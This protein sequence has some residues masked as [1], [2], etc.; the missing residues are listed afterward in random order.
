M[1]KLEYTQKK[2]LIQKQGSGVDIVLGDSSTSHLMTTSFKVAH[3][4]DLLDPTE[5]DH[6]I[7]LSLPA[8]SIVLGTK[9]QM[10]VQDT[11]DILKLGTSSDDDLFFSGELSTASDA[12]SLLSPTALMSIGADD[13]G[14]IVLT[15]S[16]AP[17]EG[18][19]VKVTVTFIQFN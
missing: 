18:A 9:I 5:T 6:I 8:N 3:S 17:T 10:L 4:I 13:V 14:N 12:V 16:E 11:V 19:K 2:G 15:T 7:G 1:T